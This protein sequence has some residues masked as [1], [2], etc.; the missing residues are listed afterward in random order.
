MVRACHSLRDSHRHI[1]IH[2]WPCCAH[3]L[4]RCTG[5]YLR[6]SHAGSPRSVQCPCHAHRTTQA[7]CPPDAGAPIDDAPSSAANWLCFWCPLLRRRDACDAALVSIAS[8]AARLDA[9]LL[10]GSGTLRHLQQRTP[11]SV[12][13]RWN[14]RGAP[15]GARA[16]LRPSA[17]Y[18]RA[19][20]GYLPRPRWMPRAARACG[21]RA[22][23]RAPRDDPAAPTALRYRRRLLVA[24]TSGD[25]GA[26]RLYFAFS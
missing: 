2:R 1:H 7:P 19:R 22:R 9:T 17:T 8:C 14:T 11:P 10:D 18:T 12:C 21:A 4:D 3:A 15:W 20:L 16:R 26:S 5:R 6:P 24:I 13:V 23:A 25:F